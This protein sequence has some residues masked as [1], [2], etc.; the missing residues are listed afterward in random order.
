LHNRIFVIE[1][2]P[3]I[4]AFLKST[5]SADGYDVLAAANGKTALQMIS[6]HCPDCILLDLGLPDM[7]GSEIIR[8]VRGRTATPILVISARSMEQDKASTLDAGADD[9]L[10]KPYAPQ[11]LLARV[12]A[13]LR[14]PAALQEVSVH[15]SDLRFDSASGTLHGPNGDCELSKREAAMLACFLNNT[16]QV[17]SRSQLLVSAWGNEAD[18]EER[19]IDNFVFLVR[20]RLQNVGSQTVIVTVRGFGYR[21]EDARTC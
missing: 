12:R 10:T 2:D 5:L 17:L 11:E 14:R 18:V 9:Y 1:D 21:L 16:N 19:N 15:F 8:S 4:A 20:R 3:G 6:S 7:D 13:L